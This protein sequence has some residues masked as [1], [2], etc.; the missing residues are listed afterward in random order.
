MPGSNCIKESGFW[1]LCTAGYLHACF[2]AWSNLT[3]VY[4]YLEYL[5]GHAQILYIPIL[6]VFMKKSFFN[7]PC[8]R[9]ML[10]LGIIDFATLQVITYGGG[11]FTIRGT[12]YCNEKPLAHIMGSF[13]IGFWAASC[14]ACCLLAINRCL[15]VSN[16][17]VANILFS[18]WRTNALLCLPTLNFLYFFFY[19][20]PAIFSA[21]RYANFFNPFIDVPGFDFHE[22]E[23]RYNSTPHT[24]NNLLDAV[25]LCVTYATF[26]FYVAKTSVEKTTSIINRTFVQA[27]VICGINGVAAV[28][29]VIMQ[30]V[31]TPVAIN[32]FVLLSWQAS[33]GSPVF[34]YL[35]MNVSI[36]NAV[37]DLFH[38]TRKHP[39]RH[40][41]SVSTTGHHKVSA[42]VISSTANK[43]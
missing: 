29:C 8:Y 39:S 10:Y 41:E 37:V 4:K 34:I 7:R 21:N 22:E 31:D 43:F 35:F 13:A 38:V 24:V 40:S 20:P 19:T 36:R 26:C 12:L 6:I 23:Q 32:I 17:K 42:K 3:R 11:Y 2:V 5:Y 28:V 30:F 9:I 14:A 25:I 1:V 15:T 18:G 27:A 33:H 16:P